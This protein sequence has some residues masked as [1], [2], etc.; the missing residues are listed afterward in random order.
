MKNIMNPKIS[1]HGIQRRLW[2]GALILSSV[3]AFASTTVT[4]Q[5]DMSAQITAGTFN[6]GSDT[7][8]ASGTFNGWNTTATPLAR[9]GTSSLYQVTVND[10]AD[11][12]PGF[13]QYKFVDTQ[14]GYETTLGNGNGG[15]NENRV[16][17]LPATSGGSITLPYAYFSRRRPHHRCPGHIFGRYGRTGQSGRLQSQS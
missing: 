16:G 7:I 13:V 8:S 5:V 14:S 3:P 17:T 11:P 4:F 12:N 9:V 15:N 6:P 10:A 2:I 1:P